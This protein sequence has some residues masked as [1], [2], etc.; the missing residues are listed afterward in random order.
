MFA[1]LKLKAGILKGTGL[2][3]RPFAPHVPSRR[4]ALV[5]R[6]GSARKHDF[7]VLAEF[8]A[9]YERRVRA[10]PVPSR[11]TSRTAA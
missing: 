4:I 9:E 6:P 1:C 7:D 5:A 10:T 3:A 8:I 11:R 2:V